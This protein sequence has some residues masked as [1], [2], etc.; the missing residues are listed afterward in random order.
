MIT[1]RCPFCVNDNLQMKWSEEARPRTFDTA[2][3]VVA[4]LAA[5]VAEL[6][7]DARVEPLK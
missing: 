3:F 6:T 4:S 1:A 7:A 5:M 2:I